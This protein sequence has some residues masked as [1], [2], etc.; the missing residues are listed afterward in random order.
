MYDPPYYLPEKCDFSAIGNNSRLESECSPKL[1]D[2]LFGYYRGLLING[3]RRVTFPRGFETEDMEVTPFGDAIG[4]VKL[5]VAGLLQLPPDTLGFEGDLSDSVVFVAVD[6]Q[7]SQTYSGKIVSVGFP[8]EIPGPI[9][10][11]ISDKQEYFTIDLIQNLNLPVSEAKYSV[12]A[13][14][15]PY[16]SNVLTIEVRVE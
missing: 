10:G 1:Q 4:A 2:P 16:K 7:T 13:T 3:P 5:M 8:G 14:L 6:Q 11:S 12:Y 15:G 9:G